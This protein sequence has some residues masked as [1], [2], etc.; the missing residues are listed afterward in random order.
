MDN[1]PVEDVSIS[2]IG[3]SQSPT[4]TNSKGEFS[5]SIPADI[6]VVIAFYNINYIQTVRSV[7]LSVGETLDISRKVASKEN[8]LTMV[9]VDGGDRFKNLTPLDPINITHIPTA[10]EDF[11]A[12]L[13]TL[14]G[15]SSRI[16][17]R[18]SYSVRG[19]NFDEN[20]VY[21]NGIEVYRPFLTRSGQQEGLSFINADLVSSV[22]FSA[23]GF[24]AKYG[25]KMSS[26]LD[27]TYRKPR[28]FA[29][30]VSGSLLG[31]NLHLEGAAK[32]GL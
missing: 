8:V 16:E 12:I 7:K 9:D 3:S 6:D 20:L 5:Y 21:V 25:D 4:Y 17:L 13:F 15:V 1:Q 29:G 19:G 23:G 24:E 18:S 31:S 32:N 11:N 28:K 14:P 10:S 30:T 2:I 26:V 22:L 27:V